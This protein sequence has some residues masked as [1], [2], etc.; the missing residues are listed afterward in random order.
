VRKETKGITYR[1]L[2]GALFALMSVLMV[3]SAREVSVPQIVFMRVLCGS[4][5]C[6]AWLCITKQELYNISRQSFALYFFRSLANYIAF[7]VW[8]EA[9]T[10][11]GINE[12]TA[13][14]YLS[15]LWTFLM[16]RIALGEQLDRFTIIIVILNFIG[17]VVV[18]EPKLGSITTYG[19]VTVIFSTILWSVYDIICKRQTATE[20]HLVQTLYTFIITSV[21]AFPGAVLTWKPLSSALLFNSFLIGSLGFINV[22]VLFLAY[23]Y[24]K[25]ITLVPFSYARLVFTILFSFVATMTLPTLGC[26]I[27]SGIILISNLYYFK[28]ACLNKNSKLEPTA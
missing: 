18:L 28:K 22:T 15:P 10:Y 6:F 24:A 5:V 8:I 4:V 3:S 11:V 16:A 14:G 25:V 12:A 2:N 1:L 23:R 13:I 26:I 7:Y 27:G 19:L 9:L 17:V 20:H 21:I